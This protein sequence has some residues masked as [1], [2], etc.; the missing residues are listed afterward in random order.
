M[1]EFKIRASAAGKL[2]TS[3]R[4]KTETLSETTKTYL[5]EWLTSEIYGVQ[6]NIQSKYLTKGVILENEAIDRVVEWLDFPLMI[7]NEK[8]FEDNNFQGT[9]DLFLND[10]TVID[11]KCSWDCFTF[12]LFETE[13]PTTD[14][15][16]QLQVYMW[17]T[18]RTKAKLIYVLLN[19]PD[20]LSYDETFDYS[21][22]DKK[23]RTKVFD[24]HIDFS[25]IEALIIRVNE[26]RKYIET[27]LNG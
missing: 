11:I 2:M 12:P 6:K 15:Y 19:T 14:Y 10:D 22:I 18:C 21:N 13:I 27:L 23:Y 7:K 4:S 1:K 17:L 16:Y 3:P 5:K 24:I 9:P 25:I 26:S 20:G 8:H